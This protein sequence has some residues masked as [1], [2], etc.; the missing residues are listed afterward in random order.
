M[1][2]RQR[3]ASDSGRKLE[4]ARLGTEARF[5]DKM[6]HP[7]V[8]V[9]YND[10]VA[11]AK[12]AGKR[13]PTEAEWEKASRGTDARIFPWGDEWDPTRLNSLE[14]GPRTTTPVGSFPD[15]ASPYGALDMVGNV[16]ES[17]SDWYNHAYYS[18]STQWSNPQG[19]AY[20]IHRA[21]RGACWLNKRHVTRCAHRD[22]HVSTP[23]FRIHL[24][25]FRC[26]V[27]YA[28]FIKR[29]QAVPPDP[30]QS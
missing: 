21:F 26:A 6:N 8:Q 11:Y 5:E 22:N 7:V 17:V 14:L 28:D 9:S 13:L 25:G 23:D 15:G 2:G 30:T 12:W 18:S 29:S 16:W 20:G 10:A 24:G 27:S 19:P 1:G 3:L 4:S